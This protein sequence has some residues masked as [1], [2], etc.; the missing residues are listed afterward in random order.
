MKNGAGVAINNLD[1]LLCNG[2]D[3]SGNEQT[4]FIHYHPVA[5]SGGDA[6]CGMRVEREG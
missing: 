6:E 2:Y 1:M 5:G 3:I 4:S